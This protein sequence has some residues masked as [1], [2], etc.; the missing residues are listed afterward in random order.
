[1]AFE[2]YIRHGISANESQ[3]IYEGKTAQE[4]FVSYLCTLC[5]DDA[6][7]INSKGDISIKPEVAEVTQDDN[8]FYNGMADYIFSYR[9]E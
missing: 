3:G 8:G 6:A 7:F 2:I 4:A 9:P 1:M 5:G